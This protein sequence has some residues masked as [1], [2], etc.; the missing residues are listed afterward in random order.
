M[1]LSTTGTHLHSAAAK[2]GPKALQLLR[3]I[4]IREGGTPS[5]GVQ[6]CPVVAHQC[7]RCF[8]VQ[9]RPSASVCGKEFNYNSTHNPVI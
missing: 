4:T 5:G 8:G 9:E 3:L 2:L 1:L 6:L 7:K